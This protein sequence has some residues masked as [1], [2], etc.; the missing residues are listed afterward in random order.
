MT[1]QFEE[2]VCG[3]AHG[4]THTRAHTNGAPDLQTAFSKSLLKMIVS[5]SQTSPLILIGLC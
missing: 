3:H 4:S 5:V 1:F 2:S